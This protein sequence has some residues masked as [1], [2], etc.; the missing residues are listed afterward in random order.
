MPPPPRSCHPPIQEINRSSTEILTAIA[1]IS[2]GATTQAAAVEE[3]VAA[4]NQI[5]KGVHLAEQ[6][7]SVALEKGDAMN[8]LLG[9]N[10]TSVEEMIRGIVVAMEAGKKSVAEI[11]ELDVISRKIDKIVDAIAN[12]AIQTSMLAV[13][14]A[15]EAARAGEFGKGFAVV[16]TD[17]Q[18]LANDAAENAE[19]IKDLVKAIQDQIAIVRSDLI[20]IA[21]SSMTEVEKAKATTDVLGSIARDMGAVLGNNK[22]IAE[23]AQEI[24]ASVVQ[25][26][27]GMEQIAA[28][29]EQ[30]K[31][32]AG[33]ASTAAKQ[34]AQGAEELSAAIDHI[35]STADELQSAA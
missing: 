8:T 24:A 2:D 17:I 12:V 22:K 30:A 6:R 14:G 9:A 5:E 21:E 32:A 33:Q 19:Q 27:T 20:G 29:A 7:A 11:Q 15:V 13:N 16:S 23:A 26:K 3:G 28:A 10:K 35:A 31:T 18:N 34:Q 25:A 4:I 1:Q